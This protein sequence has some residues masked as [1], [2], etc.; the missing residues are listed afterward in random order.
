MRTLFG[1]QHDRLTESVGE[2]HF[3][4]DP[5]RADVL[6]L[7][8]DLGSA[9]R[10]CDRTV[11]ALDAVFDGGRETDKFLIVV[12]LGRDLSTF[13]E[14]VFRT[15][16][17]NLPDRPCLAPARLSLNLLDR[18]GTGTVFEQAQLLGT[19]PFSLGV[20]GRD[21]CGLRGRAGLRI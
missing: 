12:D 16:S 14:V 20:G 17:S 2:R 7:V 11:A 8:G 4:L 10:Y 9:S 3:I 5:I 21:F 15:K 6:V 1:E 19:P 18:R 13:A